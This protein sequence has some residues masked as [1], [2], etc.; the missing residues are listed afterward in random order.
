MEGR[1]KVLSISIGHGFPMATC[2]RREPACSSSP[3]EPSHGDA[4]AARLG[5]ELIEIGARSVPDFLEPDAAIDAALQA[6]GE[7]GGHRRYHRQCRRRRAI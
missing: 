4:L 3:T 2:R 6:P 1:D 7:A 5:Q